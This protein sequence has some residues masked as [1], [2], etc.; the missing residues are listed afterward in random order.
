MVAKLE[1]VGDNRNGLFHID[2]LAAKRGDKI[3]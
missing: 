2:K 1:M 3:A